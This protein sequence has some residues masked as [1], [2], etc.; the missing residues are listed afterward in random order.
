MT[1]KL[2]SDSQSNLIR[3]ALEIEREEASDA[4]CIGYMARVLT[5][6]TIPHSDPKTSSFERE[7]GQFKITITDAAN[8]G[9]PFGSYPRLLL[10]WMTTEA[11]LTKSRELTLGRSLSDFMRTV[12]YGTDG[13]TGRLFKNHTARLF[14]SIIS[15]VMEG[16]NNQQ[17]MNMPIAKNWD[18]WWHPNN[19]HQ[20]SLYD[21]FVRLD[22]DFFEHITQCPVPVDTRALGALKRS[23]MALDIYI[24]LT[25]R[26]SYLK[27]PVAI[28]WEQLQ[29]QL[30]AGYAFD[31]KGRKNFQNAFKRRLK[32]VLL[33][34][35]E[36]R[37]ET[38][39]GRLKLM[40]SPTHIP[41]KPT[42]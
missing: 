9:L 19:H 31:D 26:M 5:L 13:R 36:A 22:Q 20:M 39:R 37:V 35:P 16:E 1:N 25:Y 11:V 33:V 17:G 29:M 4:G 8:N 32:S 18:I 7:N 23:P 24:W 14:G 6:A 15:C 34:Y 12:G 41:M 38:I 10:S 21:S 28:T 3:D 42:T 40:P 30:G 27:K 2:I